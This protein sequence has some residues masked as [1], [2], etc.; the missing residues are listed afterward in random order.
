MEM[1][2]KLD[3]HGLPY[4]EIDF[5]G[6]KAKLTVWI[7]QVLLEDG[8]VT[9]FSDSETNW[10]EYTEAVWPANPERGRYFDEACRGATDDPVVVAAARKFLQQ[11]ES[12]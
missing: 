1:E 11:I 7:N 3:Q 8:I 2:L 6:R 9:L 4:A 5:L 12:L 10:E